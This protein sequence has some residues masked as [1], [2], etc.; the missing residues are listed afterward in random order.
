MLGEIASGRDERLLVQGT[1]TRA[2]PGAGIP[3]SHHSIILLFHHSNEVIVMRIVWLQPGTANG[4]QCENCLRDRLLS[5]TLSKAGHTV[6][7]IPIYLPLAEQP[8]LRV[9]YGAIRLWIGTTWPLFQRL[10]GFLN[11]LLDN[12]RLLSTV[13]RRAETSDPSQGAALTLA[14]LCGAYDPRLDAELFEAIDAVGGKPD[15]FLIS[16]PLL[17]HQG[18]L[19]HDCFNAPLY[20]LIGGEDHWVDKLGHETKDRVWELMRLESESCEAFITGG[21]PPEQ[22][23][24]EQL[25]LDTRTCLESLPLS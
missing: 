13:A 1:Q 10:P 6:F 17:A 24:V 19:V 23:L 21:T 14:T 2:P 22:R 11:A 7:S 3:F 25:H 16:T 20:S 5:E 9:C 12:G 15:A 18:R 4:F 8:G